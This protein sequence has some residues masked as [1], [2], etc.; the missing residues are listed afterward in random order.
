MTREERLL[1]CKQCTNRGFS[2]QNGIICKITDAI[3]A[4]EGRCTDYNED[5]NEVA[6]IERTM[7]YSAVLDQ[8]AETGGL[9]VLG[10]KS[11][12]TAGVIFLV[13]SLIW[14]CIGL[15]F[16]V[17][18]FWPVPLLGFASGITFI[19]AGVNKKGRNKVNPDSLD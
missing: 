5:A 10:I 1:Q 19:V 14:L 8:K 2:P 9:N 11:G 7:E 17:I 18:F 6:S 3:A 16:G 15:P 13:A 12:I 4:F